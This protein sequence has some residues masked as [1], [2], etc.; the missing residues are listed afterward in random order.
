MGDVRW[1]IRKA[2][3]HPTTPFDSRNASI[4]GPDTEVVT[5]VPEAVLDRARALENKWHA[6]WLRACDRAEAAKRECDQAREENARLRAV[7]HNIAIRRPSRDRADVAF[8]RCREDARA[9]L[10]Q[11]GPEK[12]TG[13]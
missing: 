2:M 12:E 4:V 6:E 8:Y 9:A 11:P 7:L 5:V 10:S 1:S 13:T 3:V